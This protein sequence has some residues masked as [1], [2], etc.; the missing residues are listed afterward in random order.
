MANHFKHSFCNFIF[1][2]PESMTDEECISLEVYK[3][4]ENIISAWR[5]SWKERFSALIFGNIWLHISGQIQPP[6][7]VSAHSKYLK[8][9]NTP[10]TLMFKS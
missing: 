3:D 10:E 2:K 6:V 1:T 8:K 4:N 9:T 5:L 7:R